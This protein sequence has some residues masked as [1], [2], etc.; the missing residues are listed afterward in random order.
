MNSLIIY[1]TTDGQ[2]KKICETLKEN[3]IDKNFYEIIS[4]EE[5]FHKEIERYE[6]IIIGASIR[7]GR[8]NPKIY[9]FIK[10]NKEVLEKKKNAFFSVNVVARK[11][12][13]NTP[14]TNPY[15]M[16]FL[17]KSEWQPKKLGV[18]AGKIDY[19]RLSFINKIAI[20]LIMFITKGPTNT[21]N[22]YEFTDWQR[23]KKFI[24]EFDEM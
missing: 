15:I 24:N 10:M 14:D 17:K 6:K 18:F 20:R 2:T 21:N 1:S 3:S 9:E 5:A 23:V 4:L 19:P 8:H 13:K 16:K 12:E 7:Y 22:T 11:S